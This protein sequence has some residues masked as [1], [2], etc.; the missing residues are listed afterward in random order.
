MTLAVAAL[1]IGAASVFACFGN[2][3]SDELVRCSVIALVGAAICYPYLLL[4]LTR[5][6][7]RWSVPVAGTFTVAAVS[8][9]F[10]TLGP[11]G[12]L[13]A[14]VVSI[15]V[16]ALCGHALPDERA[17]AWA[18]SWGSSLVVAAAVVA[19]AALGGLC[20]FAAWVDAISG[21]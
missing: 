4:F 12:I 2:R 6:R 15:A 19:M 10:H 18:D 13:P 14:F 20:A 1:A 16:M 17:R 7:L 21:C 11:L 8:V 5:S 9:A 3:T